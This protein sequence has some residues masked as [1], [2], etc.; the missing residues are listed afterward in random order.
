VRLFPGVYRHK[1]SGAIRA[2]MRALPRCALGVVFG[3]L[4]VAAG[5]AH[6]GTVEGTV[7]N[8]TTGKAAGGVDVILIARR[9][10]KGRCCC[11]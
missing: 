1:I 10:A 8:G 9:S 3:V 5:A 11:G 2:A 4:F 6:A 7:L